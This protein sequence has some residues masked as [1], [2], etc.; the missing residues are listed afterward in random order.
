MIQIRRR[1]T[2]GRGEEE[3]KGRGV[4]MKRAVVEGE[5]E[6]E[7]KRR[8]REWGEGEED[9]RG[10]GGR[11]GRG[12]ERRRKRCHQPFEMVFLNEAISHREVQDGPGGRRMWRRRFWTEDSRPGSTDIVAEA[13]HGWHP[14][15]AWG[16]LRLPSCRALPAPRRSGST[17]RSVR[18]HPGASTAPL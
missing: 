11:R 5:R 6:K 15:C 2:G 8:K 14:A 13:A 9:G 10:R 3:E 4:R 1:R 17:L 7:G 12:G 16:W 18:C